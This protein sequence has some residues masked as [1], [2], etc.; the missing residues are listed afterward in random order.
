MPELVTTE[1]LTMSSR[2]LNQTPSRHLKF[3][4]QLS[5]E[6]PQNAVC[7]CGKNLTTLLSTL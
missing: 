6:D 7:F 2:E 5:L 3:G 4:C 1:A